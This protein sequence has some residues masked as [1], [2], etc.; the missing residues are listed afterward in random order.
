MA[1]L[2]IDQ[3]PAE[4]TSVFLPI[5][6]SYEWQNSTCTVFNSNGNLGIRVD[7]D[8]AGS[9]A[10]GDFVQVL[11]GSYR[12]IYKVTLAITDSNFLSLVT[13]GTFISNDPLSN[14]FNLDTRQV[15]EL[16]AGYQTGA[17]ATV[18]PYQKI[19][20]ISVAINPT[21][22]KFEVDLQSYLRSY[23]QITQPTA[24]KDYGLSLQWQIKP[25]SGSLTAFKYSYYSARAINPNIVGTNEPLGN[26]P[27]S[28]LNENNLN[29][30]PTV[31]SV[32]EDTENAVRNIISTPSNVT[33]TNTS[34]SISLVS[35]QKTTI[36]IVKT[37]GTWG[38]MTIDPT[39]AWVTIDSV[40]GDTV[41][42]T[43]NANTVING[44]Y[45][46]VDYDGDDYLT[47]TL[48]SLAGCYEFDLLEDASIVGT[49]EVCVYPA[50][51][52]KSICTENTLNFAFV[53]R[54]GGWNSLALECKFIKGVDIGGQQT[55]LSSSNILK[56]T[57]LKDVYESYS[58]TADVLSKFDLD[59]ISALRTSIQAYLYNDDSQAFDIPIILD[60]TS[61]ETYGNRQR[62]PD[63]SASFSFRVATKEVVQTQ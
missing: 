54:Q 42:I 5:Q 47:D 15:F 35:G 16:Y 1:T 13:D 50:A 10:I 32:I 11:N 63:R 7:L 25:V 3:D 49:I 33:T 9:V 28:F 8:F 12:G 29:N 34:P 43:F 31:L 55:F 23:Y 18:K 19:A 21:T 14:K 17:G 60:S 52:I 51:Q 6:I 38:T 41:T 57:E 59:M 20:D 39:A 37:S 30:I 58:L 53:N 4:I 46:S 27:L 36:Q 45:A 24:G 22:F 62:Q 2:V 26:V 56:R 61:F 44:D 48:N 40:V